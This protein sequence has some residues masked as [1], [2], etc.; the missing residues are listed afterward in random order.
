MTRALPLTRTYFYVCPRRCALA[1]HA[2]C[3]EELLAEGALQ[4]LLTLLTDTVGL[5]RGS[6]R[7]R[8]IQLSRQVCALLLRPALC[9]C[10]PLPRPASPPH[11]HMWLRPAAQTC[12]PPPHTQ[13]GCALLPRPALASPQGGCALLP[14]PSPPHMKA[15]RP[16]LY[17][18]YSNP[19]Y[20]A[21]GL[22]EA[23][24]RDDT[25]K[26]MRAASCS[27]GAPAIKLN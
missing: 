24:V 14:R 8:P 1:L 22:H 18:R 23:C 26:S 5:P 20:V 4:L 2:T 19:P 11:T 12:L 6:P 9:G 7:L 17:H 21:A 3:K 27:A 25:S 13:G 10:A 15:T 16:G